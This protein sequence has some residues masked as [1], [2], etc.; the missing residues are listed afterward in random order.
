MAAYHCD[1]PEPVPAFTCRIRE[2]EGDEPGFTGIVALGGHTVFECPARYADSY[3][4]VVERFA[5]ALA[6]V[7]R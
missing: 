1:V 6:R 4:D 2:D 5:E 3:P 7:L